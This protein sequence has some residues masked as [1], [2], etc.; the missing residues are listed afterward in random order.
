MTTVSVRGAELFYTTKGRGPALLV[1]SAIGTGPYERQTPPPLPDHFRLVYVDLRGGGRST[2][3]PSELTFD[4]LAEDLEAIRKDLKEER[5]A[6]LGHSSLGILAMEYGRRCPASVSHVI[7]AGAPTHGNMG[8]LMEQA[9]A[10]FC[11]D[12]SEERRRIQQEALARLPPGAPPGAMLMAQ[13]P[14]RFYDPRFDPAPL[15]AEASPKMGL[16]QHLLGTLTPAWEVT[17]EPE[18]LRVPIFLAHGRC[19]YVVPHVLWKGV[20][21]KL[22]RATFHLF[23]KSGHQPF[24]EEPEAFTRA[25]VEWMERTR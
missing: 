22:P 1:L 16:I 11:E 20:V 9:K 6:V 14:S 15:F 24:F 17:K 18:S 10:F 23:E 19:D 21:E 7:T 2:G 12:A 5:V 25:V 4:Q 13:T 8:K 3:E